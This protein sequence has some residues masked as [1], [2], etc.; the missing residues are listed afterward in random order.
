MSVNELVTTCVVKDELLPPPCSAWRMSARSSVSAS[1]FVYLPSARIIA[2]RFSA[3]DF[4]GS[5]LRRKS[6][7]PLW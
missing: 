1:S 6:D 2:S 7:A 5:G 3:V 4:F